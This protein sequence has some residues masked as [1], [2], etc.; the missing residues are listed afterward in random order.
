MSLLADL[1]AKNKSGETG[2]D[3]G[4]PPT[5]SQTYNTTALPRSMKSRYV[6]ISLAALAIV[7]A[8]LVA[9]TQFKSITALFL[10]V[11]TITPPP[12][13]PAVTPA[14]LSPK[15]AE[16]VSAALPPSTGAENRAIEELPG[17]KAE[18]TAAAKKVTPRKSLQKKKTT[19]R[20]RS[21]YRAPAIKPVLSPSVKTTPKRLDITVAPRSG[22]LPVSG[23]DAVKRDALLYSARSAEMISDW[24]TALHKYRSALEFD[25]DNFRIMNNISASLNNLGNF[26]EG[27]REA[28]RALAKKPDYV[29]AMINA[30]IAYSSSGNSME[31][32][33]YFSKAST[34]DPG[35][36]NLTINLGVLQERTGKLD[37][38]Q[39]TYRQ[40]ADAGDPYAMAGMARIYERKGY[41][42][43][44]ARMYRK[45][46]KLPETDPLLKKETRERLQ[47][48]GE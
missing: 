26:D 11:Q 12:V 5:L 7:V 24:R 45:V 28:K 42:N 34:A 27:A 32:L 36:K 29:P 8:G 3:K 23:A 33:L 37:E 16:L 41:R 14:I 22:N 2:G 20:H 35:N 25:P 9:T 40:L 10:P 38:A 17:K 15:P 46:M 18:D 39:A 1:L 44:A 6:V 19:T 4:I 47:R 48:L 13:K 31:A 43:E 30:A 21:H